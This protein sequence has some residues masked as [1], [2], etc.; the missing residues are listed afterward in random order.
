MI[1]VVMKPTTSVLGAAGA[2]VGK[3]ILSS[4]VVAGVVLVAIGVYGLYK[5]GEAVVEAVPPIYN[6]V[7]NAANAAYTA[8]RGELLAIVHGNAATAAE[9]IDTV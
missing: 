7:I 6:G 9:P 8:A 5:A 2:A 3:E 1:D 4:P